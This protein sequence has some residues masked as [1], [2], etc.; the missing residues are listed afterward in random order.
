MQTD[1]I[2]LPSHVFCSASFCPGQTCGTRSGIIQLVSSVAEIAVG[3]ANSRLLLIFGFPHAKSALVKPC[4][5]CFPTTGPAGVCIASIGDGFFERVDDLVQPFQQ[6]LVVAPG[7]LRVGGGFWCEVIQQQFIIH[8]ALYL[9]STFKSTRQILPGR[10]T[11]GL[12]SGLIP[13]WIFWT[14]FGLFASFRCAAKSN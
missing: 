12:W 14:A 10:F 3:C 11:G 1:S 13:H 6:T 9:Y 7:V 2:F 4:C 8:E 5:F